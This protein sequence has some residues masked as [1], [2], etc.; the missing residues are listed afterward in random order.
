MTKDE[1]LKKF[2]QIASQTP[3]HPTKH[4]DKMKF[5][6]RCEACEVDPKEADSRVLQLVFEETPVLYQLVKEKVDGRQ[7]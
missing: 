7:D 6:Y 2:E 5:K 3:E 4:S 1:A